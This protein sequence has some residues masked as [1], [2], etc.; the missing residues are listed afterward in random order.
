MTVAALM[1]AVEPGVNASIHPGDD[2]FAYA[3]GAWLEV[4]EIPTGS[5]RWNAR[6]EIND[7]T[8]RQVEQL[9]ADAATAPAESDARKVADFRAAYLDQTSIDARGIGPLRPMFERI[10][11]VNDKAALTRLLGSDV[12]ADVDPLNWGIYNS[13]SLLGLA[14]GARNHGEA[15]HVAFLLQGGLGLV[16]RQP[17]LDPSPDMQVMRAGY[18]D[19]IARVLELLGLDRPARRAEAVM[20]LETAIAVSHASRESSSDERNADNLWTRVDFSRRAPGMDWDAFFAAAG[21]SKQQS[22]VAWQPSAIVGAARLVA[23]YP[24]DTWR[25]YLRFHAVNIHAEV[26]PDSFATAVESRP[27]RSK[28]ATEVTQQAMSGAIGKLYANAYFPADRKARVQK[29]VS[30]VIAAFRKRVASVTWL[31]PASRKQ[32]I[33]KLDAI[34]FGVGYP[35]RWRNYSNLSISPADPL[36][37]LQRIAQWNHDNALAR[38]GQPADRTDWAI[39]PEVAGAALLFQQNAYNF[40]AA[41]LQPPK[42]DAAASDAANYGAIGAIVG[43][44]VSHFV[45]TLGADYDVTGRKVRWWTVAD[46]AQ[47]QVE[48][49]P[50]AQQFSLYRPFPD[51]AVDGKLTL[52]ENVADLAGLVAAFDAYR[53]TLGTRHDKEFL[54]QQDRQFFIGF[55]RAWRARYRDDG[56][57][58]Q[59]A[60]DHAP[61]SYRVS[62]VRNLDAWYEAFDVKPGNRL[63][64]EPRARVR[65]W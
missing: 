10:D 19:R 7:L 22:F 56:L 64:L 27:P 35:E 36:G 44:E 46:L 6:N 11:A 21:L 8:Q 1:G 57:R 28:R 58:K 25:D 54:R 4:T 48:S 24:L 40:A 9:I 17:Y 30:N 59:L 31:S 61:E 55:A 26:L 42:F 50:L 43:H 52:V 62:T 39:A 65:I 41:L 2:F 60:N 15:N 34:Y 45:D 23:S 49:E 5:A 3:N 33:A 12:R 20:A 47:Y 32:A 51:A 38:V 13:A 18:Q 37:N 29:I 16:E 14:V 53:A 63:F